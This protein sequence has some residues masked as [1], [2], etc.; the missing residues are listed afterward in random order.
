MPQP[1]RLHGVLKL[2]SQSLLCADM[3]MDVAGLNYQPP[4]WVEL[5][6]CRTKTAMQ[7]TLPCRST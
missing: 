2:N 5:L 7:Q 1:N 6:Q 3:M 4:L